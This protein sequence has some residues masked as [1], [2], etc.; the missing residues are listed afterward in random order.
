MHLFTKKQH[1]I[2]FR[3]WCLCPLRMHYVWHLIHFPNINTYA[4]NDKDCSCFFGNSTLR[5][6]KSASRTISLFSYEQGRT[7]MIAKIKGSAFS[8]HA[9]CLGKQQCMQGNVI[10]QISF[11]TRAQSALG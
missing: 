5:T 1:F 8:Y 11:I 2:I 10:L 9:I 3:H 6:F 7:G 4:S